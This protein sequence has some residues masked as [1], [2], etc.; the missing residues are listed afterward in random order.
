MVTSGDIAFILKILLFI[1]LV[2]RQ[3]IEPAQHNVLC[4]GLVDL[5]EKV[6]QVPDFDMRPLS[7]V[8]TML[9]IPERP[10]VTM[11]Y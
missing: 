7:F 1:V 5:L 2:E 8:G 6:F 9:P 4:V 3:T 10:V 11:R